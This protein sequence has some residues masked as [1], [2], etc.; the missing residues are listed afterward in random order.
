[1]LKDRR[2]GLH[3]AN[4]DF[5]LDGTLCRFYLAFATPWNSSRLDRVLSNGNGMGLSAHGKDTAALSPGGDY[6]DTGGNVGGGA[7]AAIGTRRA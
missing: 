6:R 7:A 5:G 3:E 1:M 4:H 2:F